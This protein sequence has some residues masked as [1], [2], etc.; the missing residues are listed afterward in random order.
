MTL[1]G[2]HIDETF[3]NSVFGCFSSYTARMSISLGSKNQTHKIFDLFFLH[4]LNGD[5]LVFE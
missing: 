2:D 5:I 3:N 1:L 4:Q